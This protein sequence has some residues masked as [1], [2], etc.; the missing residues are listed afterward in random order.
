MESEEKPI[1]RDRYSLN[2]VAESVSRALTF[3]S[4][5]LSTTLLWRSVAAGS[6]TLD[7]YGAVKVLTNVNQLLLPIILLGLNGATLKVVAEYSSN[8]KKLG[9]TIGNAV[10]IITIN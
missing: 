8:R 4:G 2:V 3:L 6:W 10:L 1:S 5:L 7:E 9:Q